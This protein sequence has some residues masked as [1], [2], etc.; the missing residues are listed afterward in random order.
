MSSTNKANLSDTPSSAQ[1]KL[2]T[3]GKHIAVLGV[4][5][6]MLMI[7]LLKFTAIEV[8]ELKPL[9]NQTP[10]LAWLYGVFGEAGTSYLLGVVEILAA[11]L[12][13][14][15]RWSTRAAVAGGAL[16]TLTFITT[17]STLLTVPIWEEASGGFPWLNASGSF[18]IKDIALL[19]VSLMVLA[20]GMLRQPARQ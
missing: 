13:I 18:L 11:V 20:E 1:Q 9:I 7:G 15:S 3:I 5:V 2:L 12:L 14:A 19:G 6:P 16:C 10:W 4:V 17:L 8:E